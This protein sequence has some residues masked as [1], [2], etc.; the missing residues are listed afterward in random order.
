M[1]TSPLSAPTL[2]RATVWPVDASVSESS[3]HPALHGFWPSEQQAILCYRVEL[4][5]SLERVVSIEES[6]TNW[7]HGP[8]IR[9]RRDKMRV[10]SRKQLDEIEK[11]KYFLSQTVGHDIG[12]DIAASDW[13]SKHAAE[14]RDWWETQPDAFPDFD[15][16]L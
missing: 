14:W 3:Q 9:W 4:R 1:V 8:A 5:A 10:D 7:E 2:R 15:S 13:V 12:W 11:H 16:Y 6:V